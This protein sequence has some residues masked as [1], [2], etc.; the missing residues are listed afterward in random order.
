M[1]SLP[2][3]LAIIHH[4]HESEKRQKGY[5]L[6]LLAYLWEQQGIKVHH[7]YGTADFIRADVAFLHV[8]LSVVP[9]A[10]ASFARR[11]PVALNAA[12]LDIRKRSFSTLA[13]SNPAAYQGEV[14]VKT[15]LNSGGSPERRIRRMTEP[16][17]L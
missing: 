16:T 13:L 11:Y 10:Y 3:S 7:L 1:E 5:L 4:K 9:H 12:V 2:V 8:N 17:L 15:D 14:I 6:S